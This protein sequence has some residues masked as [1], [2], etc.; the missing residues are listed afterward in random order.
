[1]SSR[2]CDNKAIIILAVCLYTATISN[3]I[4]SNQT[5][6]PPD[7][8]NGFNYCGPA[9]C[10]KVRSELPTCDFTP[11]TFDYP[12]IISKLGSK[13]CKHNR[14]D[15]CTSKTLKSVMI[16]T[17]VKA[18]YCNDKY[19]VIHTDTSS[20]LPDYLETIPIPPESLSVTDGSQCVTRT[21]N[22]A[23]ATIKIPLFPTMLNTSDPAINNI[24][25]EVFSLEGGYKRYDVETGSHA[26]MGLP[27][28]GA[29][30]SLKRATLLII[31]KT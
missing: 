16:G 4:I 18:A 5:C 28:G 3:A 23:F 15:R 31:N 6:S 24:D 17:G 27:I 21:L 19:L 14:D 26:T 30:T 10:S 9:F 1:M 25:S 13:K 22:G 12:D 2:Q 7:S 11:T 29:S 8:I 20:G